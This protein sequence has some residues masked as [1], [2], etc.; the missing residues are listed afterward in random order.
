MIV[1]RI[2]QLNFGCTTDTHV[3]WQI[4]IHYRILYCRFNVAGKQHDIVHAATTIVCVVIDQVLLC[5]YDI[6]C[7]VYDITC[8]V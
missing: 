1:E 7:T 2:N 5:V 6:T 3:Q 8:T 4:V